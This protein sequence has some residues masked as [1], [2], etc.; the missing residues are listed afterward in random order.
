METISSNRFL[1]NNIGN[2]NQ[3][4]IYELSK[5]EN[6]KEYKL[7]KDNLSYIISIKKDIIESNNIIKIKNSQIINKK[8]Y[9]YETNIDNLYLN[10]IFNNSDNFNKN[11]INFI[12]LFEQKKAI[13]KDILINK[14]IVLSL[15][16]NSQNYIDIK[17]VTKNKAENEIIKELIEKYSSLEKE[18]NSMKSQLTKENTDLKQKLLKVNSNNTNSNNNFKIFN[19]QSFQIKS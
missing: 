12:S 2:I 16:I 5:I 13:I 6:E 7:I 8:F 3:E 19:N 9:L 1:I 17:L 15:K 14:E 10:K 4:G 11:Y 18:F